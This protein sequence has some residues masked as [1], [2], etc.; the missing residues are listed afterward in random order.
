M[1]NYRERVLAGLALIG[2][3]VLPAAA[4]QG[5]NVR[6]EASNWKQSRADACEQVVSQANAINFN[7]ETQTRTI[8]RCDCEERSHTPYYSTSAETQHKCAVRVDISDK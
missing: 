4:V 5:Q 3:M 2:M 7:S 6:V 1:I 8:G